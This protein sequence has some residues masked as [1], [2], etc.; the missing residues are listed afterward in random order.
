[1]PFQGGEVAREESMFNISPP[2]YNFIP[3]HQMF[4]NNKVLP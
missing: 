1:M 3:C 4:T 2:E